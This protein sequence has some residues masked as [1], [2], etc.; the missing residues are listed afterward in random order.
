MLDSSPINYKSMDLCN[1]SHELRPCMESL[2]N[3]EAIFMMLE[4]RRNHDEKWSPPL[5]FGLLNDE[6]ILLGE[7]LN[8]IVGNK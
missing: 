2:N 7:T 4:V 1:S 3:G 8:E 5:F 6:G